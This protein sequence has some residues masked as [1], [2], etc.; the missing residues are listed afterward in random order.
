MNSHYLYLLI[1]CLTVLFP[2]AFSFHSKANFSKKWN[3]LWK[4]IAIPAAV[5]IVW[6]IVFTGMGVWGFNP[7]Y[8]SG[9]YFYNLPFE[10][11]LFFI[12]IPYSC[13]FIYEAVKY[14]AGKDVL[15]RYKSSIS[16]LLIIFLLTTG[17]LNVDRWY[18]GVAFIACGLFIALLE[19]GWKL[20]FLGLFYFSFLFVLVPFFIVNGILTGSFLEEPVVW[21]NKNEMLDFRLGTIPIEDLFYGMLLLLMNVSIFEKLQMNR[22]SQ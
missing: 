13:V 10:E 2:L 21:Y 20:P 7:A 11:I 15:E 16:I 9:I 22:Q 5:F 1:D 8:V 3:Y 17:L 18:T 19:W 4:A 14:F 12:C 6:D